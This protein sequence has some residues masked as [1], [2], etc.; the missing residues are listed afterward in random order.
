MTM[1]DAPTVQITNRVPVPLL[2]A[3]RAKLPGVGRAA[4]VRVALAR[5][6]GLDSDEFVADLPR[7]PKPRSTDR[8]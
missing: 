8:T 5:L 3:A 7:G 2:D 1:R 6:A 4:L